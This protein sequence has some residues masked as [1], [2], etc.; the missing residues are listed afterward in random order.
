MNSRWVTLALDSGMVPLHSQ[1][2]DAFASKLQYVN[3]IFTFLW[4]FFI[5]ENFLLTKVFNNKI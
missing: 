1:G 4:C 3:G 2:L 5:E